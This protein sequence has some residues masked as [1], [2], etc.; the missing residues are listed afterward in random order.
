MTSKAQRID[1]IKTL[2]LKARE[3]SGSTEAERESSRVMALR[4]M[5]KHSITKEELKSF[6]PQKPQPQNTTKTRYS[7]SPYAS[8]YVYDTGWYYY[9]IP[10]A[11][12]N[13]DTCRILSTSFQN[14]VRELKGFYFEVGL[15]GTK[16][17]SN[18]PEL[19]YRYEKELVER[20]RLQKEKDEALYR[21][22]ERQRQESRKRIEDDAKFM[23]NVIFIGLCILIP[24]ILAIIF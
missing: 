7:D 3:E 23:K 24:F 10:K 14:V 16:V 1:Q 2:L 17:R 11:Y 6:S 9:N 22:R 21:I 15:S 8:R 12:Q 4:L 5:E 19:L 13:T 18:H 20:M